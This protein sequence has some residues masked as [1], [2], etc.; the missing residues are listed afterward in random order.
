MDI[1]LSANAGHRKA[2]GDFDIIMSSRFMGNGLSNNRFDKFTTCP[3][4]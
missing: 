2:V 1:W 3:T 4:P